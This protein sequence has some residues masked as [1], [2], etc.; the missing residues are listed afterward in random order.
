[1]FP[2]CPKIL[3]RL[4]IAAANLVNNQI[5][6][7]GPG[8]R[9]LISEIERFA[10]HRTGSRPFDERYYLLSYPGVGEALEKGLFR[11]AQHHYVELERSNRW[12]RIMVPYSY[13]TGSDQ[14]DNGRFIE[15]IEGRLQKLLRPFLLEVAVDEEWYLKT[16]DDVKR[17][18]ETGLFA[19]ARDHYA[20]AGY[21]ED[22]LPR[23]VVVDETWYLGLYT[24]VAEA[25]RAGK[26]QTAKE[27]FI[28]SGFKEGRLPSADWSLRSDKGGKATKRAR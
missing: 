25:I 8:L 9:R 3:D 19:S 17:A 12:G 21:F 7:S 26:F 5:Q 14:D 2:P 20:I 11:N 13:L 15:V 22:R 28:K 10:A 24:D 4:G 18:V 6:V 27:H 1:V 23:P 16:N